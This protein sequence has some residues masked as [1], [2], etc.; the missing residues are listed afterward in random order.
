M[1][2][3]DGIFV[4]HR[5]EKCLVEILEFFIFYFLLLLFR[6]HFPPQLYGSRPCGTSNVCRF[7]LAHLLVERHWQLQWRNRSFRSSE[8]HFAVGAPLLAGIKT[9]Q[10]PTLLLSS[11]SFSAIF[12]RFLSLAVVEDEITTSASTYAIDTPHSIGRVER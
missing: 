12:L 11:F 7:I 1:V 8:L 10:L 6:F 3:S 9:P 2:E 4:F 5:P